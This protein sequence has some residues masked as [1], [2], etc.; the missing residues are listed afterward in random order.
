MILSPGFHSL[1]LYAESCA[2][3]EDFD[4]STQAVLPHSWQSLPNGKR[5]RAL[6]KN[7][8]DAKVSVVGI[9]E[10]GGERRYGLDG[11]KFR[12]SISEIRSVSKVNERQCLFCRNYDLSLFR[13]NR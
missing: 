1:F 10:G 9:F 12:V 2:P 4:V 7:G 5:L 8:R 13:S 6:L 3:R 11:Q